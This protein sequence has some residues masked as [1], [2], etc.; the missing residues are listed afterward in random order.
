MA[1]GCLKS[2]LAITYTLKLPTDWGFYLKNWN[3]QFSK[4]LSLKSKLKLKF[5]ASNQWIVC[6]LTLVVWFCNFFYLKNEDFAIY[7]ENDCRLFVVLDY[8][9]FPVIKTERKIIFTPFF[10]NMLLSLT[11]YGVQKFFW[12]TKHIY[13]NMEAF[14]NNLTLLDY[15]SCKIICRFR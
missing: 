15:L 3:Y 6:F 7:Y 14:T 13:R 5:F 9:S 1:K 8:L 10:E 11:W 4:L 12:I 2:H